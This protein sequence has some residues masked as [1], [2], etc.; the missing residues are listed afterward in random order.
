M[1]FTCFT[2]LNVVVWSYMYKRFFRQEND[3]G[4]IDGVV[5]W[6]GSTVLLINAKLELVQVSGK[7]EY[8]NFC[9]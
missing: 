1:L 2:C 5:V 4:C 7:N 8:A 3:C 6:V 9:Y